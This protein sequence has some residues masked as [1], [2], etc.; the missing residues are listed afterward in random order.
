MPSFFISYRRDDSIDAASRIYDRLA[1]HFGHD[2]VFMDV[3]NISVGLDFREYIQDAV[4]R[5]SVLL[6]V[7]GH[8]WLIQISRLA[9]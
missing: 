2:A 3:D 4:G 7:I 8:G 9:V 1:A 5:C 6:A